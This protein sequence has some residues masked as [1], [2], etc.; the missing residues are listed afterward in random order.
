MAG[1]VQIIEF[2]TS[3]IDEIRILGDKF[4]A[5]RR[6]EGVDSRVHSTVTAD[7]DH[8]GHY[9]NIVEF[10]SYEKAM[11]NSRRSETDEFAQQ[12]AALCDEPPRFHN[13]DVLQTFEA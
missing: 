2:N 7:R 9:M 1:F 5:E 11:E 6:A 13:L 3:H 10:E 4:V 8:P 12:L